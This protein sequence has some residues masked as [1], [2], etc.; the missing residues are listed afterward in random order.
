[1]AGAAGIAQAGVAAPATVTSEPSP[2]WAGYA[3][4]SAKDGT[5]RSVSASWTQPKATCSSLAAKADFWIG[6]DGV[7]S[8]KEKSPNVQQTGT[9]VD[10]K[11]GKATY[12]AW[13]EMWPKQEPGVPYKNPVKP[14]DVMQASVTADG[15][16][17]FAL[18]IAD[19][20][21]HW[22]RTAPTAQTINTSAKLNTAEVVVEAPDG[23]PSVPLANFGRVTFSSAM[24]NATPLGKVSTFTYQLTMKSGGA[25]NKLKNPVRATPSA[26]SADGTEFTVIWRHT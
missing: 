12:F 5:F 3:T 1:M 22:S 7:N 20:T 14:G 16:G 19:A 4:V 6:I 9:E 18:R 8:P 15:S 25:L 26:F 21:Q 24:V 13:Y 2:N 23:I 11:G 10:C 17:H